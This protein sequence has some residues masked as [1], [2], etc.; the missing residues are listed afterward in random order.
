[1]T[2]TDN[3]STLQ[4]GH[5]SKIKIIWEIGTEPYLV[6]YKRCLEKYISK[7]FFINAHMISKINHLLGHRIYMLIGSSR[8]QLEIDG[9]WDTDNYTLSFLREWKN[10]C[11]L[12]TSK[13]RK[14]DMKL[15]RQ[16][17]QNK[18]KTFKV[19]GNSKK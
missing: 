5:I 11:H 7:Q 12:K 15:E 9:K 19:C 3:L 6:W 14:E 16:F 18:S 8:I 1:M 17:G 4:P 2:I 13:S 10:Y